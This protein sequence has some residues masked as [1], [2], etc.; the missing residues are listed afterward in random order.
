[1]QDIQALLAAAKNTPT[2]QA[3]GVTDVVAVRDI[4]PL[5]DRY[6]AYGFAVARSDDDSPAA[7]AALA[8]ALD[9]GEPFVPPLYRFGGRDAP[10]IARISAAANADTEAASHP[11]FGK[12]N[13]QRFHT[14]GTLQDIGEVRS[15]MLLCATPAAQ[16]GVT[17]LFNATGAYARLLAD[18]EEAALALA[19]PGSLVRQANINGCTNANHGP[20]FGVLDGE[21]ATRYAITD[22]DSW[23]VPPRVSADALWRGVRYLDRASQPGSEFYLDLRLGAGQLILLANARICHGR[24]PY[25]DSATHRRCMF[26]SLHLRRPRVAASTAAQAP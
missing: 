16:G 26:R 21:L 15:S 13:G 20:A 14:D 1:M 11:S 2:F 10:A 9:L 8:A 19:T 4:Q 25:E 3:T 22:T 18:D 17:T 5:V 7:L 24:T 23:A 6:E 12:T